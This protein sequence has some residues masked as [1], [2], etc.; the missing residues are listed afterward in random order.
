VHHASTE[1][2]Q[3]QIFYNEKFTKN[4]IITDQSKEEKHAENMQ[5][6]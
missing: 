6:Q 1:T 2:L 3:Q 5:K 4:K